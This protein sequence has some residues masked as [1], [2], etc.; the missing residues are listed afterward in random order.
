MLQ[1]PNVA[2]TMAL[3]INAG[4][5]V[6]EAWEVIAYED[7]DELHKTDADNNGRDRE[8]R[9]TKDGIKSFC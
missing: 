6:T 3:L 1:F 9:I 5:I 2:S 7:E 4:M 8:W